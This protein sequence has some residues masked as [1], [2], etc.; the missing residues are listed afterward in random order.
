VTA[1]LG[2]LHA[3]PPGASGVV[4]YCVRDDEDAVLLGRLSATGLEVRLHRSARGE[5][6][7]LGE[8]IAG[9][10][11][12]SVLYHCGPERMTRQVEH[13]TG[14]LPD[15][16]VRSERFAAVTAQGERLGDP[17]TARRTARRACC[18]AAPLGRCGLSATAEYGRI[19]FTDPRTILV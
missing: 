14:H 9:L 18:P 19:L 11:A 5:R 7:N 8:L 13:L 1:I 17:F 6:L 4:Y 16:R 10:S 15:G 3:M 12:G 2:L